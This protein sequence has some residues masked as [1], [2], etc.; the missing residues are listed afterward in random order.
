MTPPNS[1]EQLR[2]AYSHAIDKLECVTGS[3]LTDDEIVFLTR[4]P[5]KSVF[6]DMA[7]LDN[8]RSRKGWTRTR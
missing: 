7:L 4:K 5:H 8:K 3:V 1:V 6:V 2:A